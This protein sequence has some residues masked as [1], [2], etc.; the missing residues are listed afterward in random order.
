MA[1]ESKHS[2]QS[3]LAESAKN[4]QA[5]RKRKETERLLASLPES[6]PRPATPVDLTKP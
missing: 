2:I 6:E 3:K 5:V 4:I 1:I